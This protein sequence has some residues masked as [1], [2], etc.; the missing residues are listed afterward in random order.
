LFAAITEEVIF[1]G[2]LLAMLLKFTKSPHL[3]NLLQAIVFA[4]THD[5]SSPYAL[6][7]L[8]LLG[9]VTGLTYQLT[10][11]LWTPIGIHFANNIFADVIE[12]RSFG[13]IPITGKDDD[14]YFI[15]PLIVEAVWILAIGLAIRFN[16]KARHRFPT[17]YRRTSDDELAQGIEVN[18]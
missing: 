4:V 2:A 16:E 12:G 8:L 17:P 3:A 10:K 13:F 9:I 1:R 18:D 14:G 7:H 6:L 5:I 11:T 15:A